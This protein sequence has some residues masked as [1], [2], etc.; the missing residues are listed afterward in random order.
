[1][2]QSKRRLRWFKI[3]MTPACSIRYAITPMG[4]TERLIN[5]GFHVLHVLILTAIQLHIITFAISWVSGYFPLDTF[6]SLVIRMR[7]NEMWQKTVQLRSHLVHA[8]WSRKTFCEWSKATC[9]RG[10]RTDKQLWN[11]YIII[12]WKQYTKSSIPSWKTHP[13]LPDQY[14]NSLNV[15]VRDFLF[16]NMH[17]SLTNY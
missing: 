14:L 2:R 12:C 6:I 4:S 13:V 1:M 11:T 3:I 16:R 17:A 7:G 10:Y 8:R 9:Q 5:L 15:E